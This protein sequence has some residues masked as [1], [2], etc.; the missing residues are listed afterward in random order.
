MAFPEVLFEM[1]LVTSGFASVP[2]M[3]VEV[4]L[5][6]HKMVGGALVRLVT[7][8]TVNYLVFLDFPEEQ[9]LI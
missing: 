3:A 6:S 4:S 2:D 7:G 8:V 9:I 1:V 5:F